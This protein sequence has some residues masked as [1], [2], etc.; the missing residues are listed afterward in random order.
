MQDNPCRRRGAQ[1]DP[2]S[3]HL[4]DVGVRVDPLPDVGNGP[5]DPNATFAD[6]HLGPPS[7]CETRPR[8][9]AVEPHRP[10]HQIARGSTRSV[11]A[12]SSARGSSS[13]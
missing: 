9:R 8:E 11:T 6:E 12:S 4:D 7:R 2:P 13:R 3:I 10:R 5:I 1:V